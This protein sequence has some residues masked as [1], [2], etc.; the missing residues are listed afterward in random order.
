MTTTKK[1]IPLYAER[2]FGQKL[3]AT[4]D[5]I[6]DHWRVLL[7]MLCY[8][9]IPVSLLMALC[10]NSYIDLLGTPQ[11]LMED[12]PTNPLLSTT[13]IGLVFLAAAGTIF[14]S[15]VVYALMR[16]HED[17]KQDIDSLVMRSLWPEMRRGIFRLFGLF[18][19]FVL[20][21]I[22]FFVFSAFAAIFSGFLLIIF[23]PLALFCMVPLTLL[24]PASLLGNDGLLATIKKALRYG[25]RTW[26]STAAI[27][28][29]VG[30][31]VSVGT[32]VIG[33][34][35]YITQISRLLFLEDPTSGSLAFTS[36]PQFAVLNYLFCAVYSFIWF[37]GVAIYS[38]AVG[39][40]YGHA[41]ELLDGV[42]LQHDMEQFETLGETAEEPRTFDE[43]DD[44]E[45]L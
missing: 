38:I 13:Y 39:Y 2:T 35:Y 37:I 40:Q 1:H 32:N 6:R 41:A 18:L 8:L 15:A 9:L 14:A 26:G 16:F 45:R 44:F 30:F 7:R 33:I 20:V 43:I 5:F 21:G 3:N 31:L 27:V 10:L 29:V 36:T 4:F 24:W 34:P 23:Y 11:Y 25:F 42:A 19:L 28:I 17:P 22:V 12:E